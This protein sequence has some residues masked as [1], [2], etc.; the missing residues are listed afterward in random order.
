MADL[1]EKLD[2]LADLKI[3]YWHRKK[4]FDNENEEIMNRIKELQS[5]VKT[6]LVA[7]EQSV[8]T[9]KLIVTYNKGK[10]IWNDDFLT[11][12]AFSH[13]EILQAKKIGEPYVSF[14]LLDYKNI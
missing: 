8:R 11:G 14:R 4:Q 9:D 13:P 10:A 3:E 1:V 6:E 12:Y 2:E 7:L 5:D